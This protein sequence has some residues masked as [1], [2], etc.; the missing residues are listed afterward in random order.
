MTAWFAQYDCIMQLI[1]LISTQIRKYFMSLYSTEIQ[2]FLFSR[3]SL[4][5]IKNVA[6]KP[7]DICVKMHTC[8]D[9]SKNSGIKNHKS[10]ILSLIINALSIDSWIRKPILYITTNKKQTNFFTLCRSVL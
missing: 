1:V 6:Y 10:I 5:N 7:K 3:G 8:F 9:S 2:Q 4:Y